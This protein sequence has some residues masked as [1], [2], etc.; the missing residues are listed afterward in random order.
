VRWLVIDFS[1]LGGGRV[2]IPSSAVTSI[3]R[4]NIYA[5]QRKHSKDWV[6]FV[7]MEEFY[8]IFDDTS[9]SFGVENI[10]ISYGQ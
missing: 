2:Q 3:L 1:R 10:Y 4:Y 7:Q 8:T 5:K 6:S 9:F